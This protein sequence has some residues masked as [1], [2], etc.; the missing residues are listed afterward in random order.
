ML[1]I[2]AQEILIKHAIKI[3][4]METYS[5]VQKGT[6]QNQN[7]AVETTEIWGKLFIS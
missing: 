5:I 4:L 3:E 1:K 7:S 2:S 6:N